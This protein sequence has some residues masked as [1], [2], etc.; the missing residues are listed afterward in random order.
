MS[1]ALFGLSE[2]GNVLV[3][4]PNNALIQAAVEGHVTYIQMYIPFVKGMMV[5]NPLTF[6][7]HLFTYLL[8]KEYVRVR[9]K[10]KKVWAE[11]N[12][13]RTLHELL[14]LIHP[15]VP[16]DARLELVMTGSDASFLSTL[17]HR[18]LAK[19]VL[20]ERLLIMV[21]SQVHHNTCLNPNQQ[22]IIIF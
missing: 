19:A 2:L 3:E 13:K 17:D 12:T 16:F 10:F 9:D 5:K 20:S 11:V 7:P 15:T 4:N 8:G 21:S 14:E 1:F 6:C 22:R 18:S